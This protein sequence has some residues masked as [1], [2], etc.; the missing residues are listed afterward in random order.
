MN[1]HLGFFFASLIFECRI[2][3]VI[4]KKRFLPLLLIPI[5]S[6]S[7]CHE[8]SK[9]T[10]MSLLEE[11]I[12]PQVKGDY[13]YW[14][15]N[16]KRTSKNEDGSF[17]VVTAI[18]DRA[19][20]GSFRF[21]YDGTTT[22][23]NGEKQRAVV[24]YTLVSSW[25]GY[26]NVIYAECDDEN[27]HQVAS[28]IGG[29]KQEDPTPF[30]FF[31]S[32]SWSI[33]PSTYN[34]RTFKILELPEDRNNE[35]DHYK[36]IYKYKCFSNGPGNLTIE[37]ELNYYFD[38]PNHDLG[39]ESYL[40]KYDKYYIRLLSWKWYGFYETSNGNFKEEIQTQH[41]ATFKYW[42]E[43]TFEIPSNWKDYLVVK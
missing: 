37:E 36:E 15:I 38:K 6:L 17:D 8:I 23:Q 43:F 12:D 7:A 32:Y 16:I 42:K 9:T 33:L 10:A 24:D 40:Y 22:N 39:K 35:D 29:M 41:K 19:R 26:E 21:R 4:M 25:E 20:D 5:L 14:T 30:I 13:L 2:H 31:M 27:G 1:Y 28:C 18:Y 34:G 3:N 11:M